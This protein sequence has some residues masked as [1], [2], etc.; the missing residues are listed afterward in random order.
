V[1][2]VQLSRGGFSTRAASDGDE[3][4]AACGAAAGAAACYIVD[5]DMPRKSGIECLAI[6]RALGDTTPALLIT[7]GQIEALVLDQWTR[8]LGKPFSREELLRGVAEVRKGR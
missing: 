1:V 3:F 4:L 2:A 8:A 6:R 5:I 7:G